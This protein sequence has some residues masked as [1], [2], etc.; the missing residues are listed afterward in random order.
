MFSEFFT[1]EGLARYLNYL[2]K[3]AKVMPLREWRS[4]SGVILR[5]DVDLD[6]RAARR[7]CE[8]EERVGVSSTYF[9]LLSSGFYNPISAEGRTILRQMAA[10]GFE[11]GLHFDPAVYGDVTKRLMQEKVQMEADILAEIVGQR[12]ESVSLHNPSVHGKY[13]LF[14][15]FRNAYDPSI[16]ADGNYFADSCMDFRGKDPYEFVKR[17]KEM[18]IQVVLHPLHYSENGGDYV[19]AFCRYVSETMEGIDRTFRVN[20]TYTSLVDEGELGAEIRKR[21]TRRKAK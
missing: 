20:K 21:C 6:L 18:P 10:G 12:V 1:Y 19:D 5:H 9:I 17:A 4:G 16:F 3:Q 7:V 14:K 8:V 13:P 2:K 11:I 15:G